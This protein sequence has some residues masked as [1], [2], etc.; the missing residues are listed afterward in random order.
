M[1]KYLLCLAAVICLATITHAQPQSVF[2]RLHGTRVKTNIF[3]Q[4][5]EPTGN[6][7]AQLEFRVDND[8][9][10]NWN[11]VTD[12]TLFNVFNDRNNTIKVFLKFYNPLRSSIKS[13]VTEIDDPVYTAINQWLANLPVAESLSAATASL[14]ANASAAFNKRVLSN[15]SFKDL[16]TIILYKWVNEFLDS[17]DTVAVKGNQD[18]YRELVK[19]ISNF[20]KDIDQYLFTKITIT[21]G[22]SAT[23]PAWIA[24]QQ[25]KLYECPSDYFK[26]LE[27]KGEASKVAIGLDTAKQ[28]AE[29]AIPALQDLLVNKYDSDI[30]PFI[31]AA[32]TDQFRNYSYGA[33]NDLTI[34]TSEL[35]VKRAES[36]MKYKVDMSN[37]NSFTDGFKG[38]KTGYRVEEAPAF[39]FTNTKMKKFDYEIGT[40]NKDGSATDK[41]KNS[42]SF[43]VAKDQRIVPFVSMGVFYT[44]FKYPN[45][46]IKEDNDIKTVEETK[47][48]N[49][50]VRPAAFL[51]FLVKTKGDLL[52]PFL[53]LGISTGVN[54]VLFPVGA[55]IAIRDNFSISGGAILGQVKD[56]ST[57]KPG[58][59]V[60]DEATL[61]NDLSPRGMVSWYFSVNYNLSKK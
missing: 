34:F 45:Y 14:E 8:D 28:R 4:L 21:N 7:P 29:K 51:N 33:S 10:T 56:L 11:V 19:T 47:S 17:Q 37:L 60:K 20:A 46:A 23:F 9:S 12:E 53:Q 48:T 50:R 22:R 54:D 31:K 49:V 61:K 2:K 35:L 42:Y 44:D 30:K 15:A 41:K 13:T 25:E 57:L 18:K 43:T 55:G 3:L 40:L 38:V 24:D 6:T 16:Q 59:I 39:P 32:K 58:D 26:F 5:K 1:Y 27:V 36:L 52:Y